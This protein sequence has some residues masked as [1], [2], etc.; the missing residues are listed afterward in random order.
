MFSLFQPDYI[1]PLCSCIP[2]FPPAPTRETPGIIKRDPANKTRKLGSTVMSSFS[3]Y[4]SR[5]AE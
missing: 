4:P 2:R 3:Q 1:N 5:K